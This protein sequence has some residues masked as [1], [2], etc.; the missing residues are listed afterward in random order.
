[1]LA[2]KLHLDAKTVAEAVAMDPRIG[3]YGIHG[4]RPFSGKCLTKDIIAFRNYV[5]RLSSTSY[6]L[7]ATL[8]VNEKIRGI[9]HHGRRRPN[10]S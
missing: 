4:G 10:R 6:T 3:T 5:K 1:M 9:V 2:R 8:R 7:N